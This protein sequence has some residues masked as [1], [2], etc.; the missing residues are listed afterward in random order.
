MASAILPETDSHSN[1]VKVDRVLTSQG[2]LIGLGPDEEAGPVHHEARLVI[3]LGLCGFIAVN[4]LANDSDDE[5]QLCDR[6][7]VAR[8]L[9][10][11]L[12]A[13]VRAD[14]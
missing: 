14:Q 7:M 8:P 4:I 3:E 10:K 1:T 13:I 9:I 5:D 11:S 6:L 2:P 12:Q